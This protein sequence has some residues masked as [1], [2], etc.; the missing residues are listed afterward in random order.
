MTLIRRK[1]VDF[2]VIVPT[3]NR[4]SYLRLAI[5]SVLQQKGVTFEI[6]ISDD[7]S[8]DNTEDIIKSFKDSR[9]RYMKNRIRLGTSLNFRQCF[10]ACKGNYIFT[11]GDDDFLLDKD[12]LLTVLNVME[13]YK[14]GMGKIGAVG[15]E[16]TPD[17]PYQTLILSD[18]VILLNPQTTDN[19]L[20][21][22][23]GFGLGY[24][25]GLIFNRTYLDKRKLTVDHKCYTDHMCL[26]Y[27]TA[28]YDLIKNHGIA[29]I[30]SLVVGHLSL[31]LI[32]RYFDM[33]WHGRL[34]M[35]EPIDLV[36]KFLKGL[37]FEDYKKAYL[38]SQV[39][40]LPNIKYFSSMRNYVLVLKRMVCLDRSLIWDYRFIFWAFMGLLPNLFIKIARDVKIYVSR[41]GVRETLQKYEY[42]KKVGELTNSLENYANI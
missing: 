6:I 2:S 28:A 29:Y 30:P 35:E 34:F 11:L 9:I 22:S 42:F 12:T 37:E 40:V 41:S 20:T 16:K 36:K 32:A 27:H 8:P 14:T 19:I 15:Y 5:V 4:A 38:R 13:K 7:H 25:S 31:E 10:L 1:R 23:I 33:K 3:Y 18:K 26:I 17:E 39:A 21:K 24:F